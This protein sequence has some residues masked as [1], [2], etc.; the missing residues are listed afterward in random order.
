[1]KNKRE[2]KIKQQ[3]EKSK[4]EK[5]DGAIE[6]R[7]LIK[8]WTFLGKISMSSEDGTLEIR[9]VEK[10]GNTKVYKGFA[11]AT[12]RFCIQDC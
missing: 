7:F 5:I 12:T 6:Q 9:Y 1:L 2:Q 11:Y 10:K 3:E 8:E 4:G